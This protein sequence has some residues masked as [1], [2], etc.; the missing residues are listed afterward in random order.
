MYLKLFLGASQTE[1]IHYEANTHHN[2]WNW[3][4]C[5]LCSIFV[6]ELSFRSWNQTFFFFYAFGMITLLFNKKIESYFNTHINKFY[7]GIV[8]VGNISF[9]IYLIHMYV[10][11]F[12]INQL[13]IESCFLRI[14]IVLSISSLIIVGLRLL[15][16]QKSHRYLRI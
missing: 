13:V 15:I 10:I 14:V 11:S 3:C 12:L 5:Y 9:G 8:W 4:I 2:N 7:N 16:P 6:Q 1:L